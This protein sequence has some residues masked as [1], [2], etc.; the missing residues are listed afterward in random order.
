MSEHQVRPIDPA[1]QRRPDLVRP[2]FGVQLAGA[3][4]ALGEGLAYF[5]TATLL[6]AAIGLR[7]FPAVL[8]G[9]LVNPDTYMR[10]VR[11]REMLSQHALVYVV[12]RDSAGAGTVLHWSHLIDA[13]LLLLAAPF[14]PVSSGEAALHAAALAFGPLSIGLL[15]AAVAWAAAPFSDRRW[16]W[17]VPLL[18][19]LSP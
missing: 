19:V 7:A 13:I 2:R 8:Q 14:A 17:L 11:L 4:V 15:A 10:L 5:A 12:P 3:P 9:S 6:A 18:A 16:R 1:A